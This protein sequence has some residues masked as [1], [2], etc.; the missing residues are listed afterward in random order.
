MPPGQLGRYEIVEELGRGAMGIV[1]KA[2]DPLI[3]R[4]VA[5]KTIALDL[6]GDEAEAFE[7]RFYR[8]AKSAGRLN[9]SSIVTIYDVGKSGGVAYIAMEYL[10]GQS[11]RDILDSGVVIPV[12]RIA[13]IIAQVADGLAFA[14]ENDIVHRDIKP[15]NIMVLDSRSVKIMDFGIAHL[16]AGSR[17]MAGTVFGS[18]KY[19]APERIAG[20]Q[21]DGRADIFSLGAVLYEMLTGFAPFFAGDL[22]TL[23]DQVINV[24]PA[25]PRSRN[26][27]IPFSFDHIVATSMAKRPEDRY[28]DARAMATA[29]RNFRDLR[30]PGAVPHWPVSSVRASEPTHERTPVEPS[31]AAAVVAVAAPAHDDAPEIGPGAGIGFGQRRKLVVYGGTAALLALLASAAVLSQRAAN[32]PPA[33]QQPEGAAPS[34]EAADASPHVAGWPTPQGGASTA[35]TVAATSPSAPYPSAS[36]EV[37]PPPPAEPPMARLSLAVA[38]WGEV[39]V[40]GK[41][42]GVAPPLT[43]IRLAPGKHTIEI[44]NT[45]FPSFAQ[46]VDLAANGSLKIRHKFQ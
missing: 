14:H 31:P 35:T 21:V 13:D 44:R 43:E 26:K 3:D 11:L 41:R 42:K 28:P 18:P 10:Q 15:A 24:T 30:A 22:D 37:K 32:A 7:Q 19:M 27:T 4:I 2:R 33:P 12:E 38:P 36:A 25:P 8:E 39:Y 34:A 40:D 23:L 5:L 20:E 16:P 17:T 29:V 46:S 1:Y 6:S 45:T 9:H